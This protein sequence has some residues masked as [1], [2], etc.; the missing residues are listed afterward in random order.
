MRFKMR[1]TQAISLTFLLCR[2]PNDFPRSTFCTQ[3]VQHIVFHQQDVI[4]DYQHLIAWL[5]PKENDVQ[6]WRKKHCMVSNV[7]LMELQSKY[8]TIYVLE[9]FDFSSCIAACMYIAIN[10]SFTV[11]CIGQIVSEYR[12]VLKTFTCL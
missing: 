9:L 4:G 7:N 2:V 12:Q 1:G 6:C 8:Y 3:P 10:L 5:K 11:S